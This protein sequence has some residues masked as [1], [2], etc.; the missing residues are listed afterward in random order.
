MNSRDEE[1][2]D[3]VSQSGSG[4]LSSK[5]EGLD[6]D[7]VAQRAELERFYMAFA[8]TYN[9]RP[10]LC[11]LFWSDEQVTNDIIGFI[12]WGLSNNT[13]PL[14]TASF[15][16][17]LGSLASA[18]SDAAARIWEVLVHNNSTTMKKND[19]SKISIDSLY[20]SLKY[21][22]DALNENFE[23]DLNDQL[24]L[25]QKKQDFLFSANASQKKPKS[26]EKIE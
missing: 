15:C 19:Y 17:L 8:Y 1:D 4:S 3:D 26:Q 9:N 6:L 18:G 2:E 21:Y 10:E 16:V 24:K 25:N 22:V 23:Q 13:S 14:I 11:E 5:S 20:D 12:S 7:K